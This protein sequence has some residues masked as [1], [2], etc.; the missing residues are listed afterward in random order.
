MRL[1]ILQI[2]L[3]PFLA[4]SAQTTVEATYS[5]TSL[6]R[7]QAVEKAKSKQENRQY[8]DILEMMSSGTTTDYRLVSDGESSSFTKV[9]DEAQLE[10]DAPKIVILSN[11]YAD[12]ETSYYKHFP[13]HKM[14]EA[15]D[16]LMKTYVI[17]DTLGTLPWQ[18]HH[19]EKNILGQKCYRA[20]LGD[21]ITA[22]YC[23]S[24][25]VSDGPGPYYGLP[26]LIL[27]VEAPEA[28][29]RCQ[30]IVSPSEAKVESE[31]KGKAMSRQDFEAFKMKTFNMINDRR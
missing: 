2:L 26:G 14:T 12:E 29:Y 24:V 15:V 6:T 5:V 9:T 11:D 18:L 13:S 28:V 7:Q 19:E 30:S 25:P 20:T 3:F 16:F 23:L 31:K 8:S 10:N 22:W 17:G 4:A 27:D 21:S 1:F